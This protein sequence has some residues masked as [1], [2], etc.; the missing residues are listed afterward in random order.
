MVYNY[1]PT[2]YRGQ[3]GI[4]KGGFHNS[5]NVRTVRFVGCWVSLSNDLF[6]FSY[7]IMGFIYGPLIASDMLIY[8]TIIIYIYIVS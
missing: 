7:F 3:E 8:E 2:L 1:N 5:S 4:G 6:R